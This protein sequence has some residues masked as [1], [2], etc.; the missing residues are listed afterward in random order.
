MSKANFVRL[1]DVVYQCAVKNECMALECDDSIASLLLKLQLKK[2]PE[3]MRQRYDIWGGGK[4]NILLTFA[5][6]CISRRWGDTVTSFIRY[7]WDC[8]S[9]ITRYA[10][11]VRGTG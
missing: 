7:K 5:S 1:L 10:I 4:S 2:T 6:H 11:Q 3:G 8:L 9:S